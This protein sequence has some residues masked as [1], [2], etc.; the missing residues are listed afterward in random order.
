MKIFN[1]TGRENVENPRYE[2]GASIMLACGDDNGAGAAV[3]G[4]TRDL[5][6]DALAKV[7]DPPLHGS[8]DSVGPGLL[9]RLER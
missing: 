1:S 8:T 2:G 7:L 5:G 9:G 6:F 3:V 4:L